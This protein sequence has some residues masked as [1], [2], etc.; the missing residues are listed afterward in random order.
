MEVCL[1]VDYSILNTKCYALLK[2]VFHIRVTLFYYDHSLR[3]FVT[4][5]WASLLVDIN[6]SLGCSELGISIHFFSGLAV[7]MSA[8][9]GVLAM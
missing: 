2:Y 6:C 3:L 8:R 1:F 5:N 9:P 7:L 4:A